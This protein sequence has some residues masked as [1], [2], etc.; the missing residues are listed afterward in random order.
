MLGITHSQDGTQDV[1]ILSHMSLLGLWAASSNGK[2]A[3][4]YHV[5]IVGVGHR[6][7]GTGIRAWLDTGWCTGSIWLPQP[8]LWPWD[9]RACRWWLLSSALPALLGPPPNVALRGRASPAGSRCH[10]E[11]AILQTQAG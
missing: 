4:L 1:M 7:P 8:Q 10:T 11:A 3:C 5:L 6:S 2:P 9:H